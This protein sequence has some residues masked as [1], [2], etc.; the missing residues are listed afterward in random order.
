MDGILADPLVPSRAAPRLERVQVLEGP[1]RG[2]ARRSPACIGEAA[3]RDTD[4]GMRGLRE[5]DRHFHT[6]V[7]DVGEDNTGD[8]MARRRV[9]EGRQGRGA[10]IRVRRDRRGA[11]TGRYH[12]GGEG[13]RI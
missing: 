1:G 2:H 8:V 4:D 6:A 13:C 7:R 10:H 12:E 9:P 11:N 3:S 5:Q